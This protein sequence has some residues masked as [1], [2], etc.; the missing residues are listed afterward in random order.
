LNTKE[1]IS[2]ILLDLRTGLISDGLK[3]IKKLEPAN[4]HELTLQASPESRTSLRDRLIEVHRAGRKLLAAELQHQ[5]GKGWMAE[6]RMMYPVYFDIVHHRNGFGPHKDECIGFE[7]K[8]DIVHE[9]KCAL[10]NGFPS[11]SCEFKDI[12]EDEF[13]DLDLLTDLTGSRVVNDV[14]SR[15]IAAAQRFTLLGLTENSLLS[16]ITSEITAGSVSYIDR[17]ATGLANK[18]V[19]I[20]RSDEAQ[21]RSDEWD[22]IEYSALL[23]QNVCEFCASEDGKTAQSEDDLQPAP[24]PECLGSDFCRCFL[25]FVT[26]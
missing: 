24:N 16:A 26:N 11:C 3:G 9:A 1:A 20:G 6:G 10:K 21:S 4:Y 13:D 12:P 17:A 19:N 7:C 22:H 8:C 5:Q 15:I 23:D 18:V 25:V 2:K 14:Q